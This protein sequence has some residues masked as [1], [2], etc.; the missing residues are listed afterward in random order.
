MLLIFSKFNLADEA[1][2]RS[3]LDQEVGRLLILTDLTK[4]DL[5]QNWNDNFNKLIFDFSILIKFD[6]KNKIFA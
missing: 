3:L 5:V 1:L 4:S 6:A 2:E